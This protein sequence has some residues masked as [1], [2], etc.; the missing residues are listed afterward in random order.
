MVRGCSGRRSDGIHDGYGGRIWGAWYG[1][2]V[3]RRE[4]A[5]GPDAIGGGCRSAVGRYIISDNISEAQDGVGCDSWMQTVVSIPSQGPPAN[6]WSAHRWKQFFIITN[7]HG[8][9]GTVHSQITNKTK[10]I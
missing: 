4:T 9:Y 10:K 3:A 6:Q 2:V 1:E 7:R 8:A 5:G